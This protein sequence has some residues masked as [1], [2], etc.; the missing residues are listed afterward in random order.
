MKP[1]YSAIGELVCYPCP[2]QK[3]HPDFGLDLIPR[4]QTP[5]DIGRAVAFFASDDAS[6]INGQALNVNGG[7]IMS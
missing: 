3:S 7:A 4:P 1:K 2:Y 6:E 5:E